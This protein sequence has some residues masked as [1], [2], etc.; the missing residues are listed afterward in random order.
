VRFTITSDGDVTNVALET[1]S[2][3]VPLDDSAVNALIE[4]ILPPLPDD[5]PREQETVH[6][7]FLADGNIQFMRSHLHALKQ[8]G[9]F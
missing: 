6:A 8:A 4:V 2:G 1:S 3:C 9:H 7:R 5:F